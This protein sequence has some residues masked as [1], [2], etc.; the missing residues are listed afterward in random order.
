MIVQESQSAIALEPIPDK[1]VILTFDDSVKSHFTIVRPLL[2][3]YGFGAT[4]YITEGF[5]FHK[6]KERYLT[7]DEI[8]QMH[9]DGFEIGNHTRDHMGCTKENLD[10]IKEQV[11]AINKSCAEHGIP[12][13]VT[14]GYPGNAF[15]EGAL[16]ILAECGFQFARRGASPEYSY[17]KDRGKGFAYEPGRDHP[18]L[19]PSAEMPDLD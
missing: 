8:A 17:S 6:D 13:P 5:N 16:P 18:L 14:F 9:Q 3:E 4:F 2:Q 1:L 11:E 19:V 10:R 15:D 12:Q 7:W